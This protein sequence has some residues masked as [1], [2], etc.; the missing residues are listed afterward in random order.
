MA[1]YHFG[2][3][4]TAVSQGWARARRCGAVVDHGALRLA[5]R[6]FKA[7]FPSHDAI[8]HAVGHAVDFHATIEEMEAHSVREPWEQSY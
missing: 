3:A 1:I 2:Q 5:R 7:H 6:A 4:L 8:R